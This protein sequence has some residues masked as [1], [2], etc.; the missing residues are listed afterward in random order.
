LNEAYAVLSDRRKRGQYDDL[1]RR[2]GASAYG[3]FRQSYSEQDIFRGSDINQI[4][5]EMART[6]GFRK[7]NEI[8]RACYGEEC[9]MF[10]FRRPG[11]FGRGYI[12]VGP[13][14]RR[15][16]RAGNSPLSGDFGK[17]AKYV[18]RKI[19]GI[20]WPEKGKDWQDVILLDPAE[21]DGGGK[22]RYFHR[23]KSKELM[24]NIPPGLKEGQRIRLKGMGAEGVHGGQA[25]DLY[26]KVRFR[27]SLQQRIREFLGR[28]QVKLDRTRFFHR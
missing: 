6:F 12:F 5:E 11:F 2:F 17:A 14:L 24:V 22:A 28:L 15:G 3:Q 7:F 20:E 23:R 26:L 8:F 18:L 19:G 1:R 9:Q 21:A 16:L 13:A 10:E 25:G 4:F 27:K